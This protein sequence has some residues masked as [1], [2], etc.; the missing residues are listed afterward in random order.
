MFFNSP[1]PYFIIG[2]FKRRTADAGEECILG[3]A[4][5]KF[6]DDYKVNTIPVTI[7]IDG[8]GI[9]RYHHLGRI[10]TKEISRKIE[11]L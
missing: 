4:P 10:T 5:I 7:I 1:I 2:M 8:D 3:Q 6:L 9:I 11:S